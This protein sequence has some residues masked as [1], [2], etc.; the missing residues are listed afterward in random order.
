[1]T[2]PV[3]LTITRQTASG[4]FDFIRIEGRD[5]A[6]V[7]VRI[8]LSLADFTAAVMGDTVTAALDRKMDVAR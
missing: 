3:D 7:L 4:H 8:D 1:M 6:K 2:N 5:N